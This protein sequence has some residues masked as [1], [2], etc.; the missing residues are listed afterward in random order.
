MRAKYKLWI[1]NDE[2]L[3]KFGLNIGNSSRP[4]WRPTVDHY[5]G[6][7]FKNVYSEVVY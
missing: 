6:F 2:Q 3:A 1:A 5:V 4:G 7:N